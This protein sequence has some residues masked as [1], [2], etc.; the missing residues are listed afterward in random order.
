MDTSEKARL[1]QQELVRRGLPITQKNIS[2]MV[3]NPVGGPLSINQLETYADISNAAAQQ[4]YILHD[5]N[6]PLPGV[7]EPAWSPDRMVDLVTGAKSA[8]VRNMA[9]LAGVAFVAYLVLKRRG[10]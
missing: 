8:T 3:A 6:A 2:V 5:Y 7:V 1:A 4:D 9:V 10:A